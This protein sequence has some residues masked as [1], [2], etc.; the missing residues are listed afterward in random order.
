MN[1]DATGLKDKS[2]TAHE[3]N[4]TNIIIGTHDDLGLRSKFCDN[5][6]QV[7]NYSF[8][9]HKDNVF[10]YLKYL[11]RDNEECRRYLRDYLN[12]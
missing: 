5:Y 10:F 1:R 8:Y 9:T 3:V 2:V 4:N 7:Y 11:D 12:R 6:Y